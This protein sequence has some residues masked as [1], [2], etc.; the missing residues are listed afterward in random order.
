MDLPL[1]ASGRRARACRRLR[2]GGAV[3][4]ID[5]R[6]SRAGASSSKINGEGKDRDA[7]RRWQCRRA[8]ELCPC[9]CCCCCGHTEALSI[10]ETEFRRVCSS[11]ARRRGDS[12]ALLPFFPLSISFRSF[13]VPCFLPLFLSFFFSFLFFV[14]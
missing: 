6:L 4:E 11:V 5:T 13:L 1:E 14:A 12:A 8:R 3:S 9:R 10:R 7:L 2:R